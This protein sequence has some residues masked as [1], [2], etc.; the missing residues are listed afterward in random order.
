MPERQSDVDIP[1]PE[2]ALPV[3]DEPADERPITRPAPESEP[4]L[5]DDPVYDPSS[6]GRQPDIVEAADDYA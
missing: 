1:E 4:A 6:L 2:E 3:P 5:E